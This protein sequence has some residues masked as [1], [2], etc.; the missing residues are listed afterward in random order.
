MSKFDIVQRAIRVVQ[1]LEDKV[2]TLLSGDHSMILSWFSIKYY[3]YNC[4][5]CNIVLL[6]TQEQLEDGF[7]VLLVRNAE[8]SAL[9][10][11]NKIKIPPFTPPSILSCVVFNQNGKVA[12]SNFAENNAKKHKLSFPDKVRSIKHISYIYPIYF[13]ILLYFQNVFNLRLL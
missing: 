8:L 3:Y 13:S 5:I 1:D 11:K 4:Y 2:R 12:E 7:K 9:L 6:E 10:K